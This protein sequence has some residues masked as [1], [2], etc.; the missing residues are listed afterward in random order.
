MFTIRWTGKFWSG[1]WSDMC[2]KQCLMRPMKAFGDLTYSRGV[3]DCALS[4]WILGTPYFVKDF[5]GTSITVSE[6]HIEHRKSRKQRDLVDVEKFTAWFQQHNPFPKCSGELVSLS[7]GFVS[8]DSVDCDQGYEK[9][10]AAMRKTKGKHFEELKLHR[11]DMVKTQAMLE[12]VKIQSKEVT[13]NKSSL[14]KVFD[15]CI[16]NELDIGDAAI[17]LYGATKQEEQNRRFTKKSS[18]DIS[19]DEN[20][21]CMTGKEEF[22]GNKRNQKKSIT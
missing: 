10:V 14:M 11:A 1:T 12:S 5:L 7:S 9:G 17:I 21:M 18:C 22:L 3:T 16:V 15:E 6:Q 8:D 13:G 4:K 19:F 2:I 20:T